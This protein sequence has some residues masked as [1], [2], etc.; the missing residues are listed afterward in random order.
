MI[1]LHCSKVPKKIIVL[2][3]YKV[4]A[5]NLV[6]WCLNFSSDFFCCIE[7][8]KNDDPYLFAPIEE[9]YNKVFSES[10]YEDI[11][12]ILQV[13]PNLGCTVHA[14]NPSDKQ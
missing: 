4:F 14:L 1:L 3:E 10:F 5:D 7:A 8:G 11:C 9:R 6:L 13:P 12:L 2:S